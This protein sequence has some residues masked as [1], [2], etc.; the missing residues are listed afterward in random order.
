[1]RTL[2]RADARQLVNAVLVRG[3]SK[4][5]V[6]SGQVTARRAGARARSFRTTRQPI[7]R[8][9]AALAL[10]GAVSRSVSVVMER[11]R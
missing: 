10:T 6:A 9:G 3:W 8:S 7:A 2:S 4:A 1:M 11:S 5:V